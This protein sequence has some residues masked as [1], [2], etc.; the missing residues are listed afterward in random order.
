MGFEMS[1]RFVSCL[2]KHKQESFLLGWLVGMW[3]SGTVSVFQW[4]SATISSRGKV[5]CWELQNTEFWASGNFSSVA[6][7]SSAWPLNMGHRF[8][9]VVEK[10]PLR[11]RVVFQSAYLFSN[12]FQESISD[13]DTVMFQHNTACVALR[14]CT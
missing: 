12:C 7:L 1:P 6:N 14:V 3:L 10:D 13:L 5:L 4:S 9:D 8:P 2:A 11:Y